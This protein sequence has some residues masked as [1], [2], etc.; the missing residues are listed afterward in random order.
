MEEMT[1]ERAV[2]IALRGANEYGT[3][4]TDWFCYAPTGWASRV[5]RAPREMLKEAHFFDIASET[6]RQDDQR[7]DE[8]LVRLVLQVMRN[9]ATLAEALIER[10]AAGDSAHFA[11]LEA[12][13]RYQNPPVEAPPRRPTQRFGRRHA[14]RWTR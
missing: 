9:D 12:V 5:Q 10:V 8:E 6:E 2:L 13:S 1:L 4:D 7:E 3:W 11:L 14:I